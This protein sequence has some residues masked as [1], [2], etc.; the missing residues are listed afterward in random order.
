MS[1]NYMCS[2]VIMMIVLF[3]RIESTISTT[4]PES[5]APT[6]LP[7]TT[8]LG[9]IDSTMGD[10]STVMVNATESDRSSSKIT[11]SA[12]TDMPPVRNAAIP[13]PVFVGTLVGVIAFLTLLAVTVVITIGSCVYVKSKQSGGQSADHGYDYVTEMGRGNSRATNPI[14]MKANEAYGTHQQDNTT[15][16]ET[17]SDS[18]DAQYEELPC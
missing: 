3:H 1:L 11:V 5:T 6:T 12:N 16:L 10:V 2:L 7:V 15:I 14:E 18:V 4:L 9:N 17:P 13:I 8:I